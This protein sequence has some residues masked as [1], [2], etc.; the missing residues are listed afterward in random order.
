MSFLKNFLSRREPHDYSNKTYEQQHYASSNPTNTGD[1][2]RWDYKRFNDEL[3]Y[4]DGILSYS[5]NIS[6]DIS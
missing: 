5:D 4:A 3:F 6:D 1:N 2:G